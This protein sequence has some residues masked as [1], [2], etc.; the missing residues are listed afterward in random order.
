MFG[1]IR[2]ARF[3]SY[4]LSLPH[5]HVSLHASFFPLHQSQNIFIWPLPNILLETYSL[6]VACIIIPIDVNLERRLLDPSRASCELDEDTLQ[7]LADVTGDKWAS[8]AALLS[9]TIA[10]IE[11][12]RSEDCPAQ[13]ML[14]KLKEKEIL[15]CEQLCSR[16]RTITLLKS[17]IWVSTSALLLL[18]FVVFVYCSISLFLCLRHNSVSCTSKA[19]NMN[20][21]L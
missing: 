9:F 5:G 16:L 7:Q 3:C 17:T 15:T 11:Q 19:T 13:A 12:I 10:E 14:Q 18:L 1:L 6:M 8:I 21:L 2:L 4:T 20:L